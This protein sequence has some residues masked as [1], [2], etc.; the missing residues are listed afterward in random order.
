MPV[1]PFTEQQMLSLSGSALAKIDG[2]GRRGTSMVTFEEIEAMAALIE[3]FGAGAACQQAHHA[4][5]SGAAD[6]ARAAPGTF[7]KEQIQ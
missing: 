3:C 5:L 7:D 4:S 2:K 1:Q 6:C